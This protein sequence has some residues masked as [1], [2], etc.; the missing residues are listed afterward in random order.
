MSCQL[1][2]RLFVAW[3]EE[4]VEQC[5]RE[6]EEGAGQMGQEEGEGEMVHE[7]LHGGRRTSFFVTFL[8]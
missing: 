6:E 4:G 8:L 3:A 2:G 1:P 5:G 7:Y